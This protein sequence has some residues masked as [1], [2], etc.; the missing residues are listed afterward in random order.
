M[1]A[2]G[3]QVWR[4]SP[5]RP[6]ARSSGCRPACRSCARLTAG[7]PAVVVFEDLHWADSESVAL[8]E[9]IADLDG[10]RLLI[11]T[12]RPAEVMRRNPIAGL[13]DRLE[14]RHDVLP[15][16]AGAARPGRDV[17]AAGRGDRP[18]PAV[19][20]R[21]L[22]A[23]PHRRQPV[24]PRGAAARR[25]RPG[26]SCASSRCRGASPR[27]CAARSST[28][29]RSQQRMVEAAAV[30]GYRIPFDLLAAVTGTGED[31]LIAALRELVAQGVLVES[32]EDE[33]A[34]RHALVREAVAERLLGRERRRLHEAAL[35][36]L[37]AAGDA[38][39]GAG[40]QPR[41]GRRP[42]RRHA[43][44]GP[45]RQRGLPGDRLGVPGAAAGRDG[46][47][48]G[49][50]RHRPARHRGPGRPGWPGC[51]TTPTAYARRWH[52][53]RAHAGRP[54]RGAAPAGPAG[55]G[56]AGS[57]R[58][59]PRSARSCELVAGR[60][61]AR[62]GP[63]PRRWRRWPSRP[64]CATST[65][66]ALDWADRAVALADEFG[67]PGRGPAGRAWWRRA[68]LLAARARPLADGPRS[69]WMRWLAEAAER[70]ASG[71][72]AAQALNK[73]V[74]LP[75]RP[76][77]RPSWPSCSSGCASTPSGPASRRSRWPPTSRAGP[78]W[79][80]ARATWPRRSDAI[81]RGRAHDLG[82]RRT[83]AQSRHH[84][85][86]LAGLRLEAGDVDG[87]GPVGRRAGRHARTP[88][89][90]GRAWSSTSPAAA[91][92]WPAPL[93]LLDDGDQPGPVA[94][95]AAAAS[96][97][98]TSSRPRWPAPL[99]LG[100]VDHAGRRRST[101][102]RVDAGV[103]PPGHGAARRGARRHRRRRCAA[104]CAAAEAEHLAA[105]G[106]RHR[107]RRRGPLP[108]RAAPARRGPA[109][110]PTARPSC[111]ASWGGWRVDQLDAVRDRLGLRREPEPAPAGRADPARARGGRADRGRTDQRRAGPPALHLAADR[112]RARLEHPAQARRRLPH[113]RGRRMSRRRRAAWA[114]C[115]GACNGPGHYGEGMRLP[116]GT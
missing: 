114:S 61:A 42:V 116:P 58:R 59:W 60:P 18:A 40:G 76:P 55:L 32:G 3:S 41:P 71:C 38:D 7:G 106:P 46:A 4:C 39:L 108:A 47:R 81:E 84:G 111:C 11:G 65:T 43:R 9:R 112:R 67:L 2:T 94:P 22:A 104:T 107:P 79:R 110:A 56:G 72:S 100:D 75:A 105:G 99:P 83:G 20:G 113:R 8:F 77:R 31:E 36:A 6:A 5:T 74:H 85:V 98:T 1:S 26:A 12:Y 80:C 49:R 13:L 95:A 10:D 93:D 19:P 54:G 25:H 109:H 51:S 52:G 68:S 90:A 34:F 92:T 101:G 17:G 53:R 73:L 15:R 29:S 14:R 89:S 96:S 82:Y 69:C 70:P 86:F 66:E 23:Q 48:G 97:C 28:S 27:R 63:G 45:A 37:L 33:F 24:L 103:P 115:A 64:G 91:A 102:R 87:G 62:P 88:T 35:D 57:G 16:P 30:L 78:G 21:G 50:G 44:R